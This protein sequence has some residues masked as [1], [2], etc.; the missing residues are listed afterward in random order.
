MPR[1][2][3]LTPGLDDM[4]LSAAEIAEAR[5]PGVPM[6]R[7]GV[8]YIAQRLGWTAPEREGA[9]WRQ[10]VGRGG[11][12]EIN[13]RCLPLA[14]QAKLLRHMPEAPLPAGPSQ[15]ADAAVAERW[16][17]FDRQPERLKA[18]ARARM[19]IMMRLRELLGAH[20]SRAYAIGL[21]LQEHRQEA[22]EDGAKLSKSTIYEWEKLVEGRSVHDW[23][24][25]L[26]PAHGGGRQKAECDPEALRFLLSDWMR[27]EAPNFTSCYRR[28]TTQAAAKGWVI[29]SER[30][31]LR[32]VMALPEGIRILKRQG[33]EALKRSLP[34]QRRDRGVFHALEAVNA[35]GHVWDVFVRWPDGTIG[36]PTMCAFQDL[37]SG[38]ILAWRVEQTLSWHVVRLAFGDLVETYGVPSACW[39]DNGREFASKMITGGAPN[40]YRFKLKEDEPQGLM[41]SLGVAVHWTT[42]Y[43]G[44]AKPIERAF[45]DFAGEI[46]KHPAFHGAYTGNSP[47]AK[48]ENY[49]KAAVPLEQF[50]A[51]VGQGIAEHNA[52]PGR[53]SATCAGRS[54]DDTFA[55]SYA[56]SPIRRATED[57]CRLW[58]LAAE[59]VTISRTDGRI[60]LFGNDYWSDF[61]REHRGQKCVVRFD[62]LALDQAMHVYGLDGRY[63]GAA[64]PERMVGF[65]DVAAAQAHARRTREIIRMEKRKAEALNLMTP[66]ELAASLP[67]IEA[68]EPPE[69]KVV[70]PFFPV[71]GNA[72]VRATPEEQ[73]EN[74]ERVMAALRAHAGARPPLRLLSAEPEDEEDEF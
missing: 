55:E 20:R 25:F 3:H 9:A 26:A 22:G 61:L 44:Q 13:V 40:R 57:Q 38:K 32:Q 46:A 71:A 60:R 16:A 28:L 45:R 73:A 42:P 24:P 11:G 17:W 37:Y 72:A 18:K 49:G 14:A 7:Q 21:L 58:L 8:T 10:R 66:K 30:T 51:V 68:A 63:L 2:G 6:T 39:L 4:W 52:R 12:V 47:M 69:P 33:E 41:T 35:D 31:L 50:L 70:R 43:H 23:M 53:R 67:Q 34:A 19:K 56:R 65:N 15:E 5:L 62:P 59:G 64:E 27:P 54:F 1:D 36:R 74:E 48:P 29:P